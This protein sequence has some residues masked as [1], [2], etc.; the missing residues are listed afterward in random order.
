VNSSLAIPAVAAVG[1]AFVGWLATFFN[2]RVKWSRERLVRWDERRLTYFV[3]Y[4][5]AV[6]REVHLCVRL[7]A[8]DNLGTTDVGGLDKEKGLP[9]LDA[10]EER[11]ADLFEGLLLL[12]DAP[13]IAAA[14]RWQEVVWKMHDTVNGRWNAGQ[15]EFMSLFGAAGEARDEFHLAA[16]SSLSVRS[17]FLR[18][19]K[20]ENYGR[21]IGQDIG[22][23]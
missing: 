3:D 12:A 4:A 8:A 23:R 7:A 16:R 17:E 10:A 19:V 18:S 2:E 21:G 1:G 11:R 14:R 9:L 6:K 13:T 22:R 20:F 15:E 5:S